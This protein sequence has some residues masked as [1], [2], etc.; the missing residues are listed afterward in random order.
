MI[1]YLYAWASKLINIL[2]IFFKIQNVQSYGTKDGEV[3]LIVKM[4]KDIEVV[5]G[6][7]FSC[8]VSYVNG[9][10]CYFENWLVIVLMLQI[11]RR[12]CN[13]TEK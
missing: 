10:F 6:S 8:L 13:N 9:H 7:L 12:D 1:E 2:I 3:N 11:Q 5:T 4:N